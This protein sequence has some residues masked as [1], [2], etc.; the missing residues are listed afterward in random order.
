MAVKN[1]THRMTA[2]M[3]QFLCLSANVELEMQLLSAY[4]A[5]P[6]LII[7][8]CNYASTKIYKCIYFAA[9]GSLLMSFEFHASLTHMLCTLF[10]TY[11]T[12]SEF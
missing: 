1:G 7:H 6:F 4:G 11:M 3:T 9:F 2:H 12:D 8:Q 10:K 5:T